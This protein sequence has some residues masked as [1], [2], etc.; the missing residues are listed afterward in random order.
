MRE[1]GEFFLASEELLV[2]RLKVAELF[3]VARGSSTRRS[4]ATSSASTADAHRAAKPRE[5][6]ALTP[7]S[8]GALPAGECAGFIEQLVRRRAGRGRCEFVEAVAKAVYVVTI[9]TVMGAR[10]RTSRAGHNGR[11]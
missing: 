2:P 5:N 10:S 9:A 3:G 11:I 1:A 4:R 6:P 7:R 8:G